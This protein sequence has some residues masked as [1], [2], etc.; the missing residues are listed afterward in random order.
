MPH[1]GSCLCGAAKFTFTTPI[2]ETYAC[3]CGMC[4]K[5]F[6]GIALSVEAAPD[7]LTLDAG[8]TIKIYASSEWGERAF[9]TECG[10]GLYF[11]LVAPGPNYGTYY[12]NLGALDDP[13]GIPLTGEIFID[14]KP[15]GYALVGD[16]QRMTGA[17]FFAMIE[18]K[19]TG[20]GAS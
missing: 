14:D 10:S 4:R 3:H 2:T 6:G 20:S 8:D 16:H 11:R 19:A 7:G 5:W 15:D 12:V 13:A 17:E 1:T 9:C 18:K